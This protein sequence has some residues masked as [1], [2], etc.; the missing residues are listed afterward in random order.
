MLKRTGTLKRT[1]IKKTGNTLKRTGML[2]NTPN[3]D[4]KYLADRKAE[5]EKMWE[6]FNRH[7]E[8]TWCRDKITNDKLLHRCESCDTAIWGENKSLYHHHILEKGNS[9]YEHLKY[10][11]GN[12]MLLCEPCHTRTT[13][14]YPSDKIKEVTAETKK[15]FNII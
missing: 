11:I 13:N 1:P 6:L 5:S 10:E 8:K 12:L 7:W 14:G 3:R 9:R 4:P 15:L 2:K